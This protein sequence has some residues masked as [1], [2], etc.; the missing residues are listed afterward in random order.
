MSS[1]ALEVSA[2]AGM[3]PPSRQ[4]GPITENDRLII[5]KVASPPGQES[6][7]RQFFFW[8]PEEVLVE[9]GQIVTVLSQIA[10]QEISYQAMIDAV[11]RN[12]RRRGMGHEVDESD[13]DLTQDPPFATEGMTYAK[14][15]VLQST[16]PRATPPRE[17]SKVYLA[18]NEE[19]QKAYEGDNVENPLIVGLIRNGGDILAGPGRIDTDYLLGAN[20]GHLNVNGA[21]GRGTKSSFLMFAISMLL[22]EARRQEEENPANRDRLKIVPIIFNVKNYD[23]FYIDRPNRR[24]TPTSKDYQENRD[25]WAAVGVS[26]PMPFS[27]VEYYSPQR[28]VGDTPWMTERPDVQSYS[29]G[30][31][32]LIENDLFPFLFSDEDANNDNFSVLLFDLIAYLANDHAED[33]GS[34]RMT[35]RDNIPIN[36]L[37]ELLTWF[38]NVEDVKQGVGTQHQPATIRKFHRRLQRIVQDSRGLLRRD[39]SRGNPLDVRRA[40][41]RDPQVIDLSKLAGAGPLQRFVVAAVLQQV[42]HART[43][44]PV[45]GLKYLVVLDELNRFAPR[46]GRDPVTKLMEQIA[47]EM[48]S[49]GVILFGAQQQA[50]M[51]S[52]RVIENAGIKVLGKTSMLE[53]SKTVWS[54]LSL[55]AKQK[56]DSLLPAEKLV[57]QDNFREPLHVLVPFPAWAMRREEAEELPVSEAAQA[58]HDDFIDGDE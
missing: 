9:V 31:A 42:V 45:N 33:D 55:S 46:N 11:H 2:W 51:V 52:E 54:G 30:L 15:T 22:R 10:G 34:I 56:A 14:A 35:L 1:S 40:E 19:A 37:N 29:W 47:A 28:P 3:M 4:R 8:V 41:T 39:Q 12:S 32:D 6:T 16:P 18:T 38:R 44:S 7:S 48:R 17:R 50:S 26:D 58:S 24:F 49:Q 5:G 36:N 13:G 20:G 27:G 25:N 23:L 57:I 53:L 43:Y 21:A